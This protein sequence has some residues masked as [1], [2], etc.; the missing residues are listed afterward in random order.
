[1]GIII[2]LRSGEGSGDELVCPTKDTHVGSV[3]EI[4]TCC[5]FN[6][7]MALLYAT[8]TLHVFLSGELGIGLGMH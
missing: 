2:A 1:M 6:I 4:K 7:M 5:R 3:I 8:S